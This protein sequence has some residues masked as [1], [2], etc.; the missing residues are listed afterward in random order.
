MNENQ[1]KKMLQDRAKNMLLIKPHSQ[2]DK[3]IDYGMKILEDKEQPCLLLV[4]EGSAIPKTI[5]IAEMVKAKFSIPLI[6]T[7]RIEKI[8]KEE[9][10]DQ[11]GLKF[12]PKIEITL[13]TS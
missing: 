13:R 8:Q 10:K 9:T 12:T 3:L 1:H 2:T 11:E 5:N 6:Q 4:G 7:N